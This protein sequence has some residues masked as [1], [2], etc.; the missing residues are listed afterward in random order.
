MCKKKFIFVFQHRRK[1]MAKL[2]FEK[3]ISWM[4]T[5]KKLLGIVSV[6]K[7]M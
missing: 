7:Q 4:G 3:R 5:D 1:I 2:N 6:G